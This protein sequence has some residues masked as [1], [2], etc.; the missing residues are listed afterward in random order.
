MQ[1]AEADG[2]DGGPETD[3]PDAIHQEAPHRWE[4]LLAFSGQ[5]PALTRSH[6]PPRTPPLHQLPSASRTE[7]RDGRTS[8]AGAEGG[9]EDRP[10]G[11][12]PPPPHAVPE[13]AVGRT[14]QS[15]PVTAGALAQPRFAVRLT[16]V[17]V[18]WVG[19]YGMLLPLVS[20]ARVHK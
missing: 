8:S 9:V 7:S 3:D 15:P 1:E 11:C 14:W 5:G 13:A 6:T 16:C 20:W 4:P 19:R 18:L 10:G 17:G 12:P 2:V